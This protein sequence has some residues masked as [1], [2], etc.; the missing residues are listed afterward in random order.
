MDHRVAARAEDT[1][2]LQAFFAYPLIRQVVKVQIFS[3][4][5]NANLGTVRGVISL[6]P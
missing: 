3:L 2:I 4:A 6:A 1:Q 5:A